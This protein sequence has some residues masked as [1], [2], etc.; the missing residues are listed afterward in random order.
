[1]LPFSDDDNDDNELD[2]EDVHL[3]MSM[4][5]TN[6]KEFFDNTDNYKDCER[7]MMTSF[8]VKEW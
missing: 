4:T 1:M 8:I 3:E 2:T 6:F 5:E 7:C